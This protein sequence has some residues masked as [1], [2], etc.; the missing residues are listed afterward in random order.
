M[1]GRNR[2]YGNREETKKC[3]DRSRASQEMA[4][5]KIDVSR[6][7]ISN[8]ENEKSYPD[9][10]SVIALSDLYSVSLDELLKGDQKM[11]EHLEESTNVVKSNKKL[12]GAILLNIILMIL[13]IAL[14]I[15]LP[16]GTYYLVIVFCVV[17]M[18][19]SVLLYQ[20]IKRI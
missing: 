3:T 20:I 6:Q 5:E 4:A 1:K 10:I 12:T 15:L 14:N 18:S 17:I 2:N 8:W 16:E 7:T 19:S 13:L 11:A 9:I